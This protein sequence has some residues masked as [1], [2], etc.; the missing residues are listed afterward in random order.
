MA[1]VVRH[2]CGLTIAHSLH[3]A[4]RFI[5]SLQHRAKYGDCPRRAME[6]IMATKWMLCMLPAGVP[7]S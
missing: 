7:S 3:D 5:H 2:N 4:Y 6:A 1:E